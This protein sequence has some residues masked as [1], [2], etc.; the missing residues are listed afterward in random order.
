MP[1]IGNSIKIWIEI[2]LKQKYFVFGK[3]VVLNW[4][5][6]F[7]FLLISW[8]VAL[9][10]SDADGTSWFSP[11]GRWS[12]RWF[13]VGQRSNDRPFTS[14]PCCRYGDKF[15]NSYTWQVIKIM[16]IFT[17]VPSE[18]NQN[19]KKSLSRDY[20]HLLQGFTFYKI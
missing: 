5:F 19:S 17:I 12:S 10:Y 13:A 18:F 9:C 16:E 2:S 3:F 8:Y 4:I 11:N 15:I 20:K 1:L 14:Y 7:H 6:L